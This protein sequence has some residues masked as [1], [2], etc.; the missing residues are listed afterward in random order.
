MMDNTLTGILFESP[1]PLLNPTWLSPHL[2]LR[3]GF[4]VGVGV[5]HPEVGGEGHRGVEV[6][7][8]VEGEVG[9]IMNRWVEDP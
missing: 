8:G 6:G 9:Q 7:S 4:G 3:V 2:S 5:V 1:P